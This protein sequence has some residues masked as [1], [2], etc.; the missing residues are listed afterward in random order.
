MLADAWASACTISRS[1]SR[2]ARYC[3][4]RLPGSEYSCQ[5]C[6]LNAVAFVRRAFLDFS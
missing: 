4:L 3:V 5:P 1:P 6:H 2:L